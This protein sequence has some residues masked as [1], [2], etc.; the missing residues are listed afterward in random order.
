[1][2]TENRPSNACHICGTTTAEHGAYCSA[3]GVPSEWRPL[4]GKFEA[5]DRVSSE[6]KGI[7]C[8]QGACYAGACDVHREPEQRSNETECGC[9]WLS[10]G[11][12]NT[13]Y[14]RRDT[15]LCPVHK[16]RPNEAK[17]EEPAADATTWRRIAF[18]ILDQIP[19]ERADQVMADAMKAAGRPRAAE[20]FLE[21][22]LREMKR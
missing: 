10:G 16:Q 18:Y 22:A 1:M 7:E 12:A 8:G 13:A 20:R 4:P 3:A 15:S 21:S 2:S 6:P 5:R 9:R 19:P 11:D 14:T 17:G